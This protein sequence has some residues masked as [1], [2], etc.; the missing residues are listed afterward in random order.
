MSQLS[1]LCVML[2]LLDA[3]I[4]RVSAII[5]ILYHR[6]YQRWYA[7]HRAV[8]LPEYHTNDPPNF[9]D[10]DKQ[11]AVLYREV[12]SAHRTSKKRDSAMHKKHFSN[13]K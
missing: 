4:A 13:E 6:L 10:M 8:D 12:K 7:L 3:C 2:A 11:R 9:S 5:I 1:Q